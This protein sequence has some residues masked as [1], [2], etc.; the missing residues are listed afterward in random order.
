MNISSLNDQMNKERMNAA[1][2]DAF[3]DA[4]ESANWPG[5]AK[6]MRRAADEEREHYQKFAAYLIDRNFNPLHAD[7]AAPEKMDG[8]NPLPLFQAALKLEQDN[9][10]SIN[11]LVLEFADDPQTIALL[12]NFFVPEQTRSVRDLFDRVLEIRR[13]TGNPAGMLTLDREY[14]EAK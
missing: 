8:D 10:D 2:Y 7:L 12:Y 11:A 5:F 14:G 3:S 6:W 13:V 9:T 4:L 1:Q